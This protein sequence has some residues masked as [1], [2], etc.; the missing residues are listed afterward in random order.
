MRA[1]HF[2][3]ILF[4]FSGY[5]LIY[6]YQPFL[7][8]LLVAGLLCVA[9]MSL[10]EKLE[11]W[12]R[13][14]WLSAALSVVLLLAILFAPLFYL[15]SS[16]AS[17]VA[18]VEVERF[19]GIV[20]SAK[21]I[22]LELSALFPFAKARLVEYLEKV[23]AAAILQQALL[24]SGWLGKKSLDL[25]SDTL[26][27]TLFLFLFFYYGRRFY[28]HALRL[29]PFSQAE[30]RQLFGEVAG[31]LGVVFYSSLASVA[32]Q[33]LLFALMV[34]VMG[35]DGVLWGVLYGIA[36][37][38]PVVGGVVVWLPLASYEFY[39][40]Q[41]ERALFIALYSIIIIA[42]LADNLI[43]PWLIGLINRTILKNPIQINE[44]V[45]FFSILAGLSTFGLLGMALGPTI[46]ALFIALLRLYERGFL[47]HRESETK[48]ES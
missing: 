38:I 41:G 9:S 8:N 46:T 44:M 23:N 29:I 32:L 27:I 25:V 2:F 16:L 43:K 45:I 3:W 24:W 35:Y 15:G 31:V 7:M 12:V 39:L 5:W 14:P 28:E 26:F 13:F 20:E 33:G 48:G 4:L 21:G 6:L 18:S 34:G 10:K 40:G 37:L 36:S 42:T 47:T 17:A 22:V 1:I 30:S 11:S 19:R